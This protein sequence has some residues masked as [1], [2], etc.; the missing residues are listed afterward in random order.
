MAELKQIISAMSMT[1]LDVDSRTASKLAYAAEVLGTGS[2]R[3][4]ARQLAHA[5]DVLPGTVSHLGRL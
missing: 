1:N 5:A 4:A 2:L 3:T